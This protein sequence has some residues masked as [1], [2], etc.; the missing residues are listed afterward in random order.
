MMT[1]IGT[2]KTDKGGS[3]VDQVVSQMRQ[4]IGEKGLTVGDQLPTE[5]ELCETFGASRNTVREAMRILKTYGVVEV[6]PKVGATIVDN[7][8]SSAIEMFSFNVMDISLET[9][10]DIQGFRGLLEVSSV[11]TILDQITAEDIAD[12]RRINDKL[13]DPSEIEVAAE[14]DFEFHTRLVSVLRNKAILD[15]Y[16]LM[17]PVIL[18]I[19]LNGKTRD[20]F[21]TATFEE[22]QGVIE[23]LEARDRLAYQY[24]LKTHLETGSANFSMKDAAS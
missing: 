15:I 18:R 20:T 4:L 1:L 8:M 17:K 12:L 19:M 6:R 24:R 10:S 7:R 9:F 2:L 23:A 13:R 21:K 14:Y 11:E 5:K 22:H 16:G 3:A